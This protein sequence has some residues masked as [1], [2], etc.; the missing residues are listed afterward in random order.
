M[1]KP[2]SAHQ[3]GHDCHVIVADTINNGV[4]LRKLTMAH[5]KK[6]S[7]AL[8]DKAARTELM[9]RCSTKEKAALE[10]WEGEYQENRAHTKAYTAREREQKV[11]GCLEEKQQEKVPLT[12]AERQSTTWLL[13]R[14]PE[15]LQNF[16]AFL[17]WDKEAKNN[18]RTYATPCQIKS[19]EVKRAQLSARVAEGEDGNAG[20]PGE[21]KFIVVELSGAH[22]NLSP[23]QKD[24][25]RSLR[26]MNKEARKQVRKLGVQGML[27]PGNIITKKLR[28]IYA[29]T[30][31]KRRMA[32]NGSKKLSAAWNMIK[33]AVRPLKLQPMNKVRSCMH[34]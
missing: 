10:K 16:S 17:K 29:N 9:Q 30:T 27:P 25:I 2:I 6:V 23:A 18:S 3:R 13:S 31:P 4:P 20:D 26:R 33:A 24:L 34:V 22:D 11:L 12:P 5:R 21:A 1:T 15:A 19:D 14:K 8:T 7:L 32:A 28:A